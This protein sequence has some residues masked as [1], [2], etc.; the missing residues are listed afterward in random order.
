MTCGEMKFDIL[1]IRVDRQIF[2]LE[3]I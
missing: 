3:T 1:H 2:P